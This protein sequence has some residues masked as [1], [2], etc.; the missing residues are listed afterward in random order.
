MADNKDIVLFGHSFIRRLRDFSVRNR[1]PNL[2]LDQNKFPVIF[3]GKGGLSLN[4]F[5]TELD[6]LD[7]LKPAAVILDLGAN[8]L[9]KFSAPDPV[10]LAHKI[11]EAA[12][13]IQKAS[14][15]ICVFVVQAFHRE[16]P[17]RADYESVLSLFNITL[18]NICKSNNNNIIYWHHRNLNGSWRLFLSND[19][20]HLNKEGNKRYARSMRG[21]VLQAE[22]LLSTQSR[23]H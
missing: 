8:D 11:Y 18:R 14:S 19:G 17:R 15:A 10:I 23:R 3:H 13:E 2:D 22:K 16:K 7:F 21:A 1:S 20:I 12:V 6:V 4:N 5:H 9:D